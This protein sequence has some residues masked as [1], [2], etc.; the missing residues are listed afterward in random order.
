MS[1]D[2][3]LLLPYL[4]MGVAGILSIISTF[5]AIIERDLVKAVIY[6]ALQSTFYAI[7]YYYLVAPD[8]VLTY[9][10]VA[11][12]LTPALI[13]LLIKKTERYEGE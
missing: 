9:I 12:G 5:Y 8:L 13:L 10:P 11:V 7:L 4:V 3:T 6:S 2:T 1:Y